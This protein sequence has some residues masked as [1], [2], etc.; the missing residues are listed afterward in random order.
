MLPAVT[1][2]PLAQTI[3]TDRAFDRLPILAGARED[4]GCDDRA[5]LDHCW[6]SGPHI[7]GCRAIDMLLGKG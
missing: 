2:D 4:A 7:R 6:G 1:A 5:L 3:Y